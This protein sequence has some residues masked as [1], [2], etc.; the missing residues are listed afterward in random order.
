MQG[1]AVDALVQFSVLGGEAL[2][3]SPD[4]TVLEVQSS[5]HRQIWM[6][7]DTGQFVDK[8]VR[9]ALAY[10]FDREQMV[11]TLFQGRAEVANDHVFATFMPFFD[12]SQPP[13]RTKDIEMARQL[14][15]DAG[16]EGGLQAVAPRRRAAG[17]PRARPAD[18]VR[19]RRGRDQPGARHREP[20]HVLRGAVVPG[21]AGRPA[22]L[23]CRRAGHRRLRPPADAR[24]VPERRAQDQRRLELVAVLQ[25]A[26]S[27]TGSRRS[28]RRS[29][30][31]PRSRRPG[32]CRRSSTT[33][34]RSACRSS[35]TT[36][37]ATPTASR[38]SAS[39][40]SGRCSRTRRRRSERSEDGASR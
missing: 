16:L 18:P 35:T 31:T 33:R 34:C 36:S 7:C 3:N 39:R 30:S 25:H 27:T 4:F 24:R 6:R 32:R 17:D 37:P 19:R 5:T 21:R 26:P 22:V 8:A 23:R 20:G 40:H 38:A 29:A 1:G 12:A 11:S 10:T 15:A 14:L 9:Q 13:Q 28:R 2:L